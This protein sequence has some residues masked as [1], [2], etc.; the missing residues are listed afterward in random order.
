MSGHGKLTCAFVALGRVALVTGIRR[1]FL[2]HVGIRGS[3]KHL[4]EE[5]QNSLWDGCENYQNVPQERWASDHS[6]LREL[7]LGARKRWEFL[8]GKPALQRQV[9]CELLSEESCA[10][11]LG[12]NDLARP[13]TQPPVRSIAG[14]IREPDWADTENIHKLRMYRAAAFIDCLRP[15]VLD[16]ETPRIPDMEWVLEFI[17]AFTRPGISAE[18]QTNLI[19]DLSRTQVSLETIV[20]TARG[21]RTRLSPADLRYIWETRNLSHEERAI[22]WDNR[23]PNPFHPFDRPN[24]ELLRDKKLWQRWRVAVNYQISKAKALYDQEEQN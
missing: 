23:N 11:W 14:L 8:T 5:F 9:L 22:T 15:N 13:D 21:P 18:D 1:L 17:E 19:D 7:A 24:L 4:F 20:Q 3:V 16:W 10:E 2:P 12:F 6:Q